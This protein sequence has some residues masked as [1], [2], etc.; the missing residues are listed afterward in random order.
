MSSNDIEEKEIQM[1]SSEWNFSFIACPS[2]HNK[3]D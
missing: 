2:L 1:A 3:E